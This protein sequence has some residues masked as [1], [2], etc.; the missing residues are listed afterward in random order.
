MLHLQ[1]FGELRLTDGLGAPI[2]YPVKALV[3]LAYLYCSPDHQRSRQELARF[4][5]N[6]S[7]DHLSDLNLRKLI[8]R[9]RETT[10]PFEEEILNF[11]PPF[12]RLNKNAISVDLDILRTEKPPVARLGAVS[13]LVQ[14]GFIPGLS[15]STKAIDG[16]IERERQLQVLTLRDIF[17][18]AADHIR[19]DEERRLLRRSGLQLLETFPGDEQIRSILRGTADDHSQRRLQATGSVAIA[20]GRIAEQQDGTLPQIMPATPAPR[21][22]LLP[23]GAPALTQQATIADALIEDVTIEL[24][25]LRNI[26]VVA[27]HTAEQIRRDSDKAAIVERHSISYLLDTRLS[28]EGLYAQLIYFPT[29]EILWAARFEMAVETLPTQRRLIAHKLADAVSGQLKRNE[30]IRLRNEADPQAYHSYLVGAGFLTKFSLP[31]IR[32]ARKYFKRSLQ[33]YPDYAPAFTGLSRT[34]TSEWL[35]T[36]QGDP[37]LLKLAEDQALRAIETDLESAAGHRELGVT[38]LYQGAVDES[39]AALELAEGL[40]PHYADV[41]YSHADTLVHAS[42][43][44]DAL[45]KIKKAISLN[46]IAPDAY[47]WCAAGASYFLERYEEALAY[48]DRMKDKAPAYR[49]AAASYAMIGDRKRAQF[50]RQRAEALNPAFEVEKWLALVPFKEQWQKELYRDGLFKAGFSRT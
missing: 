9:I 38:K 18:K 24:C 31:D 16:W 21:L 4:L 48:V 40:S 5:W 50:Y 22:V 1:T 26:S 11:G 41:I 27:P 45:E 44:Q 42:R 35:L 37:A 49:I 2:R 25:A 47:L 17:I 6:E 8:S 28:G 3:M 7:G 32:R 43:P 33:F 12:V 39:V 46:P 14:R 30:S 10:T 29:D 13:D 36:T 15:A 20:S 23:P 19:D 34:F